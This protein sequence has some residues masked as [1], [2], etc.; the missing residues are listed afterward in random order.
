LAG[1]DNP[2]VPIGPAIAAD[3]SNINPVALALLQMNTF[4]FCQFLHFSIF[5]RVDF[6]NN[7]RVFNTPESDSLAS[8]SRRSDA[9]PL[10]A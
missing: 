4:Q 2:P 5:A 9:R 6:Y 1:P 10:A 8:A 7:F 3:G